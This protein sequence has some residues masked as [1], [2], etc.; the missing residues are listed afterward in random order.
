[1]SLESG[2]SYAIVG[3]SGSGKSTLARMLSFLEKPTCGEVRWNGKDVFSMSKKEVRMLRAQFQLVLQ[4]AQSSLDPR[5][6]VGKSIAE[7]LIRLLGM[8]RKQAQDHARE[9]LLRVGLEEEIAGRL[10][11][12]ISGGQQKR[13]TIARALIVHPR[14]VIFDESTSG[15]DLTVRKQI[16]DLLKKLQQEE[17][18]T[19]LFITHDID[20][21]M[22]M[23]DTIFVMKEG[24]L[25][26]QVQNSSGTD[27]FKHEYSRLLIE[28]L[29]PKIAV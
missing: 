16:L 11:H 19:F 6:S 23:A 7:P 1:M 10:P 12:E 22:Y 14:F 3:E 17:N 15:L 8:N 4:N 9:Q 5:V 18:S 21:A 27:D 28:S 13:V 20:V 26:E 25:V 2:G 24:K 29:P